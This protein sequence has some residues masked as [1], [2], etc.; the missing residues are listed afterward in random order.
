MQLNGDKPEH[1]AFM[2]HMLTVPFVTT[3]SKGEK[4]STELDATICFTLIAMI[5]GWIDWK[6]SGD[7]IELQTPL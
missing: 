6:S 5:D 3:N 1:D 7:M 4:Q 2:D